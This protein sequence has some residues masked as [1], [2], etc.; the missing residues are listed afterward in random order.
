MT[1]I[2][3]YFIEKTPSQGALMLEFSPESIP[4]NEYWRNN[5]LSAN[6]IA[7]FLTTF[8][9]RNDK[10]AIDNQRQLEIK[11]AAS[12]IA[13]ELLENAVKYCQQSAKLPITVKLYL[14]K[15]KIRF[16]ITN[17]LSL[18]RAANLQSVIYQLSH[19]DPNELYIA[20]LEKNAVD[21]YSSKSGL[22]FLSMINDYSAKLGWKFETIEDK[23]QVMNV[24]TMVELVV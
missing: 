7:D 4:V 3:G 14:D 13:N 11:G 24:T 15:N 20:Q 8:I 16:F 22:G 10:E 23:P 19:S 6:F 21:E 12:Y 9:I 1:Q 17:S 5:D 18:L 2:F